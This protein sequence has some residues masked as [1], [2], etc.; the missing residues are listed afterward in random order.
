MANRLSVADEW[1]AARNVIMEFLREMTPRHQFSSP[2]EYEKNLE[3]N[4]AA[5]IARLAN[6]KPPILLNM[7]KP[8]EKV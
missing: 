6:H 4:A 8:G 7:I 1:L 5:L 3:H 2:S